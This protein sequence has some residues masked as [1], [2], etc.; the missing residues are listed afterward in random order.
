MM[1]LY[2]Q[3]MMEYVIVVLGK[4]LQ[5][6]VAWTIFR[7]EHEKITAQFEQFNGATLW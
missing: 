4:Y 5:I 7:G 3:G 1:M 6:S 2:I